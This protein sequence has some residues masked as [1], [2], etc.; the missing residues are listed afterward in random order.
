M[1][2]CVSRDVG[3]FSYD[4]TIKGWTAPFHCAGHDSKLVHRSNAL[5]NYMYGKDMHYKEVIPFSGRVLGFVLAA[6]ATAA[7]KL[8]AFLF[9]IPLTRHMLMKC[10]PEPGQ[11]P[12][13]EVREKGYFWVSN[14]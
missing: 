1:L 2:V 3:S 6:M 11:G 8:L 9:Y 14:N 12:S 5:L 7:T 13:K 4:S 10:L